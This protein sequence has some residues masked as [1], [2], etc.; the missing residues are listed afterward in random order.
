MLPPEHVVTA[1][2]RTHRFA[3]LGWV[4]SAVEEEEKRLNV[5][6]FVLLQLITP[7]SA[8]R[9]STIQPW[10]IFGSSLNPIYGQPWRGSIDNQ[11]LVVKVGEKDPLPDPYIRDPYALAFI[12]PEDVFSGRVVRIIEDW[13]RP[14]KQ[15]YLIAA[16]NL[17]K[18]AN[19]QLSDRAGAAGEYMYWRAQRNPHKG[20]ITAKK[21][22]EL[23][24]RD[25]RVLD[26]GYY[27]EEVNALFDPTEFRKRYPR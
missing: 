24:E 6:T 26:G 22:I 13:S 8:A 20:P 12:A 10:S 7:R 1:V 14:M 5:G 11:P 25:K 15:R 16:R 4:G 17:A 19:E 21:H 3:R 27:T 9:I 2:S 18:A 23:T